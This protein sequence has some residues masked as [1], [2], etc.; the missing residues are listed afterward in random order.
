MVENRYIYYTFVEHVSELNACTH[1]FGRAYINLWCTIDMFLVA[2]QHLA[3]TVCNGL[4]YSSDLSI[5]S[6]HFASSFW[7]LLLLGSFGFGLILGI[8]TSTCVHAY[9]RCDRD[10]R[11]DTASSK[12]A[13]QYGMFL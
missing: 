1:K 6:E 2:L 8:E 11:A 10:W 9:M 5:D 4:Q 3:A 13:T 12:H 7:A